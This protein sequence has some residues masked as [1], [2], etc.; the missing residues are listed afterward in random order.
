MPQMQAVDSSLIEAIGYDPTT[1]ELHVQL[2][3]A[4]LYIYFDVE[5]EIVNALLR[6]ESK[7]AFFNQVLKPRGYRYEKRG[8]E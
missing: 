3:D 2:A 6:A 8:A 5:P 4:G 7:G 1:R